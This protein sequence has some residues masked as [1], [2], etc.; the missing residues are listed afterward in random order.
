MLILLLLLYS[1][2]CGREIVSGA[3]DVSPEDQ[4]LVLEVHQS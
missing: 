2:V 3:S 4:Y 1:A